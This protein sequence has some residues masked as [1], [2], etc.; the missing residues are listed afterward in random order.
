MQATR[1]R[2]ALMAGL[3]G[4]LALA[5]GILASPVTTQANPG[6]QSA[7]SAIAG[8][9]HGEISVS[10]TGEDQGTFAAQITV[11]VYSARPNTR[12]IV[13]RAPDSDPD[14]VC[15]NTA[16]LQPPFP[17]TTF[18]TSPGGAGATH[19]DVHFSDT[20]SD[21]RFDVRFHIVGDD[22]TTLESQCLTVAVK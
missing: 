10:P 12:F 16:Y 1:F 13:T 20:P 17:G 7:L 8:Q 14:G 9:G 18:T 22:G 21:S 19:F 6:N 3:F 4:P 11:N 15:T 5:A 2:R